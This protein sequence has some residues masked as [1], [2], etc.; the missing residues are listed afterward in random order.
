V[1]GYQGCR[2]DAVAK[3]YPSWCDRVW[4]SREGGWIRR[5][6]RSAVDCWGGWIIKYGLE[7]RLGGMLRRRECDLELTGILK[8]T[9]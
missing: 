7:S 9:D 6:A 5:V 2:C 3:S 4:E 1:E 8:M